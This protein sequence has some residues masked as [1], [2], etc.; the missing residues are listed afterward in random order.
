MCEPV[1]KKRQNKIH[2]DILANLEAKSGD[3]ILGLKQ[4]FQTGTLPKQTEVS[5]AMAEE[6][7]EIVEEKPKKMSVRDK[8]KAIKGSKAKAN[9]K[10]VLSWF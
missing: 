7:E 3:T 4:V 8:F 9:P 1:E 6:E 2:A 5:D 10:K